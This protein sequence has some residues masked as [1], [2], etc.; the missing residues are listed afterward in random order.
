MKDLLKP[1]LASKVEDVKIDFK[2]KVVIQPKLDGVRCV[3]TRNG[4]YTRNGN[5]IVNVEHILAD[6][7]YFFR[8][9]PNAVMDGEL[10]NHELKED[11]NKIISLVRK[12]KPSEDDIRESK[13]LIQFHWY[14]IIAEGNQSW[15]D[16][17]RRNLFRNHF[18]ENGSV[19]FVWSTEVKS[20]DAIRVMH[21][22]YKSQGY[23]GSIVRLNEEYRVNKRSKSL[24]KVKDWHDTEIRITSYVEG[25]GKFSGG[26]GKFI[27]VDGDGRT[28][29]VP[30]PSLTINKRR[31]V[32]ENI[33]E[34][35]GKLLTFEYFERTPDGA[36]RFPRAK[37]IRNYE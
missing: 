20:D 22:Q 24:I 35:I 15:R 31:E 19:R 12:Q 6:C 25:K 21:R 11:F 28:V 8:E 32:L 29:E 34:Y 13:R 4:A 23:E 33:E 18:P 30:W 27:G 2:K 7:D 17:E 14:D 1:M 36:Y 16:S 9:N 3:I 37:A 5:P 10:Y 26:L